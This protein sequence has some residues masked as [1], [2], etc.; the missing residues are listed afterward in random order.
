[1]PGCDIECRL[2]NTWRRIARGTTSLCLPIKVSHTRVSPEVKVT[3]LE[4][5]EFL[6]ICCS[7]G[8]VD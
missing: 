1:M 4:K 7:S 3:R 6:T 5:S 8:S 2:S